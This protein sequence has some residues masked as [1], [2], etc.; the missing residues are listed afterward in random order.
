MNVNKDVCEVYD[1]KC[2][3]LSFCVYEMLYELL[4]SPF[5]ALL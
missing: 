1:E 2:K 4:S 5:E 3:Y